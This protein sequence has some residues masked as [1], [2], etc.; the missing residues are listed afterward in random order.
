MGKSFKVLFELLSECFSLE[1]GELDQ[2][3]ISLK[4]TC[5]L[6]L[7]VN[8]FISLLHQCITAARNGRVSHNS[9]L[10]ILGICRKDKTNR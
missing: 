8:L 3:L 2:S 5:D 7:M 1:R 9:L 4:E 6:L 10:V